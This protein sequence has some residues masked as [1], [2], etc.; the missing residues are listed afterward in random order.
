MNGLIV[1][2]IAGAG[3]AGHA[4]ASIITGTFLSVAI[5]YMYHASVRCFAAAGAPKSL[6]I[7]DSE[8]DYIKVP[9]PRT[10]LLLILSI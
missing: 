1:T 2:T 6:F 4:A 5:V 3:M 8:G 9:L 10:S 7:H